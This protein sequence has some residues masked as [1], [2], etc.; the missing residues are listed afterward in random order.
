MKNLVRHIRINNY[1]AVLIFAFALTQFGCSKEGKPSRYVAKVNK[2]VLTEDDLKSAL[3]EER[4]KGN[5]KESYKY[6]TDRT[7]QETKNI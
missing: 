5:G 3:K 6:F 7:G 1:L 4:N 2:S